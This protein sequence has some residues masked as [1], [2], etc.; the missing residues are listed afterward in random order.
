M[1]GGEVTLD[2]SLAERALGELDPAGVVEVVNANMARA[3]RVVSVERGIDPRGLALVAFG[4]AGPLHACALAE[5]LGI[6]RVLVPLA[7]GVLSALGLAVAD[8]RRDY[9]GGTFEEIEARAATDLPG[10]VTARFVDARYPGQSHELTIEEGADF[11]DAHER[12]YGF[13]L[14]AEPQVV[15]RRVVATLARPRPELQCL[16]PTVSDTRRSDLGRRR[17]FGARTRRGCRRRR[18]RDRRAPR[19]DLPRPSRL[20]GRAGRPRDP[21]W[22]CD[23]PGDS[24]GDERRPLG[25]RRGDGHR[26]RP[27]RVLLEHQGAPR[28]LGRALRRPRPDGRAGRAHPGAP[29]SD[30][31]VGRGGD[32]TRPGARRDVRS[33]RP[34]RRRLA[35][36]GHHARH[37]ARTRRRDPRLRLHAG[38][39]LGRRRDRPGLD[40]GALDLDLAGGP[41]PAAGAPDRR[42]SSG[43]ARE[44]ADAGDPAGRPRRAVRR[45]PD[46]RRAPEGAPLPARGGV[47]RRDRLRRAP[48]ARGDR[49]SP[50]RSLR[51]RGRGGDGGRPPDPGCRHRR[52]RPDRDRLRRAR[53]RRRPGT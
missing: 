27:Q 18:P 39:S 33:Q 5:E 20:G 13:R 25:D 30:A 6:E 7:S 45:E 3:L 49:A 43:A 23:G 10:A 1:L 47:R 50:R 14:D 28:L 16:T 52:R 40:A 53:R 32:R 37:P 24:R 21:R 8:L 41:D 17:V 29:R 51:G 48:R 46:R 31:G 35:P 15:T 26:A 11:H 38:P 44:R 36:P 42:C 2:R 22:S 12:R 34:L 9:V 4:G 19:L